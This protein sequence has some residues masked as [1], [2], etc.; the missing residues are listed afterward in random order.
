[1]ATHVRVALILALLVAAVN[2]GGSSSP[3][4]PSTPSLMGTWVATGFFPGTATTATVQLAQSGSSLTGTW[5]GTSSG[6][7]GTLSGSVNGSS[8]SMTFTVPPPTDCTFPISVTA[9]VNGNQMTGT[10]ASVSSSCP[11]R[12]TGNVTLTKQ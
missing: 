10:Y 3:S 9:T 6:P 8:V 12:L 4:S 5:I 1:M 11:I 7:S 2:C